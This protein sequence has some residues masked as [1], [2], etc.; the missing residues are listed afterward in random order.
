MKVM[1]L[2]SSP[3]GGGQSKTAIMLE[4]LVEGMREAGADVELV[5]LRDKTIKPCVG[6][7][8]CWTRTPGT[9]IHQDD[10]TRDLFPRWL[11]SDLVVYASPLYHYTIN[12]VMK[13]FIERTLPMLEPFLIQK[14]GRTFHPLRHPGPKVVFLSVAGFPER[15]VFDHLSSWVNFI[16]GGND[17]HEKT[18]VA[19]IYRPMAEALTFPFFKDVARDILAATYEA[20]QELVTS[21]SV[22]DRTMARLVQPMLPDTGNF[23]E[24]SNLMW[25]TCMAEGVT[26]GQLMKNGFVP[27]PDSSRSFLSI[28]QMAFKPDAARHTRARLQFNFSGQQTGACYLSIDNGQISGA[29]GTTD[30]ANLTVNAPFEIWMDVITGKADGQQ[31]FMDQKY[32]AEGDLDL[33]MQMNQFFGQA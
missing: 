13:Q 3:R 26:P 30:H 12:S 23:F 32:T 9:C 2:N 1:A 18:L 29:I 31:L 25:R 5:Q 16:F 20:G 24:V 27:R 10:M 33:L 22:S 14:N 7:F 11:E 8:T 28:M 21:A 17:T 4:S 15:S 6:C 19:E